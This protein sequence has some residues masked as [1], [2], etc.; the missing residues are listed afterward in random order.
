M[1]TKGLRGIL[2]LSGKDR[3]EVIHLDEFEILENSSLVV[4]IMFF[5][6]RSIC[7]IKLVLV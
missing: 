1:G 4:I 7:I 6:I 5:K 2:T 3:S